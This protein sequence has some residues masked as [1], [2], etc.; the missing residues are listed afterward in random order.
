M[1]VKQ[2]E[3]RRACDLVLTDRMH[4]MGYGSVSLHTTVVN[5]L[6]PL[7]N[8]KK[9]GGGGGGRKKEEKERRKKRNNELVTSFIFKWPRL[10]RRNYGTCRMST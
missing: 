10:R 9:R 4:N 1:D 5:F 2:D 3:R 6:V 7:N 8:K